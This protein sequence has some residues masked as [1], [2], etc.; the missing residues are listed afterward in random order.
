VRSARITDAP[1]ISAIYTGRD[2]PF[3]DPSECAIRTNHRML[4]G[5]LDDVALLDG[6][7]VGH[8][9]WIVSDEPAPPGRHLYLGMI[10]VHP[11]AR[12]NGAGRALLEA[13]ARNARARSY[14]K[15]RT[16]PDEGALD[17]YR[18]C[19]FAH[20]GDIFGGAAVVRSAGLPR[21]WKRARSV[22]RRVVR[23]LPF[24]VGWHQACS[25]HMWSLANR[26]AVIA[27]HERVRAPCARSTSGY[28]QVRYFPWPGASGAVLAWTSSPV[29][30]IAEVAHALA[31]DLPVEVLP[32]TAYGESSDEDLTHL[33]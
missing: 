32:A 21:G 8:A 28:V 17:F 24:R 29:D 18:S 16:M 27:G 1:G 6:R 33:V 31:R 19:G 2:L 26:P 3:A 5:F 25:A 14:P 11:E 23:D 7:V 22:P 13:G 15:L 4:A 30:E 20:I 10:E 12:R 9:E